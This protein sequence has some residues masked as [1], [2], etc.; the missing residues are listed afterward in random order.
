[1]ATN[2]PTIDEAVRSLKRLL[3]DMPVTHATIMEF[4]TS[5]M[6]AGHTQVGYAFLKHAQDQLATDPTADDRDVLAEC[7]RRTFW[8]AQFA[9]MYGT[10]DMVHDGRAANDM[11]ENMH[12]RHQCDTAANPVHEEHSTLM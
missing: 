3:A 7:Y 11:V 6:E 8:D 1:M 5:S 9:E 10:E 4:A 2:T 12:I